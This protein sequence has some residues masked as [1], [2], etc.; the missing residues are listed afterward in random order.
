MTERPLANG[1]PDGDSPALSR[2]QAAGAWAGIVAA[3]LL[4]V[5][6]V[7]LAA[8]P[9]IG[10]GSDAAVEHL[11]T[12]GDLTLLASYAGAFSAVLVVPFLASLRTFLHD[13][14]A[15]GEWRWTV[16]LLS[17]AVA[18]AVVLVGNAARAGA[19]VLADNEVEPAAVSALFAA[20]KLLLSFA[21]IPISLVVITNA[22]TMAASPTPVRGLVRVGTE[23]GVLALAA[24]TVVFFADDG[25]FGP[26]ERVIGLMGFLLSLWMIATAVTILRGEAK[27]AS[28]EKRD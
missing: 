7:T 25:W 16:S 23:I 12:N 19:A 9:A 20:S 17:G 13:R 26:G 2:W 24:S 10:A 28:L 4:V 22:R 3:L 11:Q 5:D 21:L 14:G 8:T 1:P 18:V 15:D 6:V 27:V